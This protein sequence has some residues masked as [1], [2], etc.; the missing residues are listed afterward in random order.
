MTISLLENGG[1]VEYGKGYM[2]LKDNYDY[3]VSIFN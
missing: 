2:L 3:V 1:S